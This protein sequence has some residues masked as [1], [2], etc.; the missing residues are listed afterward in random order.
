MLTIRMLHLRRAKIPICVLPAALRAGREV[1]PLDPALLCDLTISGDTIESVR[2]AGP[3][4]D[5]I[6]LEGSLVFP[7]LIEAHTHLDKTHTWTR[8]PN[9]TGTFG[10]ALATLGRDTVHWTADDLRRRASFALQSAYAHGTRVL[11]THVDTTLAQGETRHAV[12]AALRAEWAG[13]IELQTVPLFGGA[14]FLTPDGAKLADLALRYGA[15]ALG[16]F[17]VAGRSLV[18]EIDA[19]LAVAAERRVGIDLHV[20]ENGNPAAE[21]LRTVAEAVLRRQFPHPVVCGHCCSLAVQPADRQ[22][23]TIDLVKSAA[24]RI[25]SLPQ[26]NV[27]LQDR[28]GSV[29]PRGPTWRGLTLI[30]DLLDAGVPVACASDNVR[31]A[32]HPYGDYDLAEVFAH[33]VALAHLDER[34]DQ[35]PLVVTAAAADAVGLP[36]FGRIAAGGPASLTLFSARAFNELLAR[37]SA[38]RRRVDGETLSAPAAPDYAAL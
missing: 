4:T 9:P 38:A 35:A 16:G 25:V 30:H 33:S 23:S 36:Q 11:R 32:F 13:R 1:D 22:R 28:R 7:G 34:L 10:D 20:D 24:I 14:A 31:D 12:M 37:P 18:A 26:C 19:L 3:G 27:Y 29:F 17:F 5:G 6:D 8:A 15:S 21:V 2:L